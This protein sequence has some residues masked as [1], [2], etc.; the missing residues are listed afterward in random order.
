MT[1]ATKNFRDERLDVLSGTRGSS[2]DKAVR[3]GGLPDAILSTMAEQVHGRSAVMT[4]DAP[5][6]VTDWTDGPALAIP[7]GLWIVSG[8]VQFR[9]TGALAGPTL[10]CA[11]IADDAVE[12]STSMSTI[13]QAAG[14]ALSVQVTALI[15]T[16]VKRVVRLQAR[17]AVASSDLVWVTTCSPY[18][19]GSETATRL[20]AVRLM[21]G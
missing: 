21:E 20:W 8:Q 12:Y 15:S 18:S 2:S 9:N 4:S 7:R 1:N 13:G 11:R 6:S 10:I 16:R 5:L 3:S 14:D 19:D 17:P